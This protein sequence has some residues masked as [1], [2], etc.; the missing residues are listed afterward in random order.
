[1]LTKSEYLCGET[2]T[3]ADISCFCEVMQMLF[4]YTDLPSH[5]NLSRWMNMMYQLPVAQEAH[6]TMLKFVPR[7]NPNPKF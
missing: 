7:Y 1:M 5:K 6:E 4:G 3:I 2:M